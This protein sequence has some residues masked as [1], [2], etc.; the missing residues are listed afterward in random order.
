M[1]GI[2]LFELKDAK[3]YRVVSEVN[4]KEAE[5]AL[6]EDVNLRVRATLELVCR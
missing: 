6:K 3:E 5:S 2:S 4:K 1:I